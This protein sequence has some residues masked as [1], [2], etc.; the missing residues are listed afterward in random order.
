MKMR[1]PKVAI[2]TITFNR[3]E[4]NKRFLKEIKKYLEIPYDHFIVDNGSRDGTAEFL[5]TTPYKVKKIIFN[6]E[7][8]GLAGAQNQVLDA[9]GNK[10]DYIVS[11]AP[12]IEFVTK[13]L[14]KELIK[15]S[16]AFKDQIVLSPYI[17]YGEAMHEKN[18]LKNRNLER[19]AYKQVKGHKVGLTKHVG[20]MFRF[21]HSKIYQIY[22]YDEKSPAY[23]SDDYLFS[24]QV[25]KKGFLQGYVEDI[26]A[27]HDN[28]KMVKD[29]KKYYVGERYRNHFIVPSKKYNA[30][31]YFIIWL[32]T[33]NFYYSEMGIG[34]TTVLGKIIIPMKKLLKKLFHI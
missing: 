31:Q 13:A 23:F 18:F 1:N 16:R 4:Y 8:K 6:K 7:N 32:K 28:L 24:Q 22:K 19:Y 17:N 12:D 33:K 10:Y 5:K 11:I 30:F 25:N 14:L 29:Y 3:L 34:K 27:V 2:Y 26:I 15:V 9:I 21:A 20:G